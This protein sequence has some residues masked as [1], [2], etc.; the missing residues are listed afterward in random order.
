MQEKLSRARYVRGLFDRLAFR[1]DLANWVITL[2][3]IRG[4]RERLV[5]EMDFRDAPRV[6]DLAAGTGDLTL[7]I[8]RRAPRTRIIGVDLARGMLQR[9]QKKIKQAGLD[10]RI[11]LIVA[12]VTALPFKDDAF[13]AI[14]N[15]FML[16]HMVSL[17]AAFSEFKRVL[18]PG[19]ILGS[20]ELTHPTLPVFRQLFDLLFRYL[21]PPVGG[22]ISGDL[23]AFRYLPRSLASF[24][25]H[26]ELLR[27][28]KDAGYE[29]TR[30]RRMGMGMVAAHLGRKPKGQTG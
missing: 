20:L 26:Q 6:L 8:A 21:I 27:I 22:L 7:T 30:C 29:E 25:G 9:G 3:R 11:S 4:W 5:R 15:A 12:D 23:E 10:G 24:P 16:R 13:D 17:P 2:G 14:T 18:R 1:Y 19:G 28:L